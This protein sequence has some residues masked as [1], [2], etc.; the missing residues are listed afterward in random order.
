MH[1][2]IKHHRQIRDILVAILFAFL[3]LLTT[4]TKQERQGVQKVLFEYIEVTGGC[5]T[6]FE[7]ECLNVRSGPGNDY[8]LVMKLRNSIVLRTGEKVE[9]NGH[10]WYKIIFDEKIRFPERITTDWYVSADYVRTLLDEGSKESKDP[11]NNAASKRIII[12]RSEQMLYAYDNDGLFM[13]EP[14]STGLELTPTPRGIFTIFRKT[15]SRYM[16][17]PIPGI[18]DQYYDLPGVPWNLYFTYQGAAIH[19]TYWHEN[20]GK[21]ASHGC[22]NLAPKNA[23]K[24]YNWAG[25][26]TFVIVQD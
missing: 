11:A 7:G 16:Q 25:V 1:E 8:P 22:V 19:G 6:H 12:D 4:S 20:F 14:I 26:G 15:P 23:E 13:K 17:G 18:A 21:Q 10:T 5:G 9:R 2:P 3:I 24:L